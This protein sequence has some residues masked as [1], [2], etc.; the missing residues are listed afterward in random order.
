MGNQTR[1]TRTGFRLYDAHRTQL[2]D[3]LGKCPQKRR[4]K[5][6]N[7]CPDHVELKVKSDFNP[8]PD[9]PNGPLVTIE[10]FVKVG[11]EWKHWHSSR[12]YDENWE[13]DGTGQIQMFAP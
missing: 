10:T 9:I 11:N 7:F 13:R 6:W 12:S 1:G 5:D 4:V 8:S 3:A 2:A